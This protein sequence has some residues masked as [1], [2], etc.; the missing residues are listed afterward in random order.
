MYSV[1]QSKE[2]VLWTP[3][4][5]HGRIRHMANKLQSV[6]SEGSLK[7][8][9]ESGAVEVVWPRDGWSPPPPGTWS[10]EGDV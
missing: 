4:A 7:A 8:A 5:A 2:M 10:W 6:L 9:L 1:E 3:G